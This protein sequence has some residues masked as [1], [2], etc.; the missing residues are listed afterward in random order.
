MR[1]YCKCRKKC[2]RRKITVIHNHIYKKTIEKVEESKT[3]EIVEK[4]KIGFWKAIGLIIINKEPKN[5]NT[6]AYM[7][8]E[9]MAWIFNVVA[10]C[11]IGLFLLIGYVVIF[12]LDWKVDCGYFVAQ[13]FSSAILLGAILII[14]FIFRA[15]AND[16]KAEKDRNYI[17]TLFFG[18]TSLAS[19]VVALVAFFKGVG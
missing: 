12:R 2:R 14:S 1:K 16:I 15:I 6:T 10:I 9:V 11:G 7:L 8:A 17:T 13:V 18:F 3:T 4:Q 5:G 19:L